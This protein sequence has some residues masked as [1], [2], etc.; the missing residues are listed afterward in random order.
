LSDFIRPKRKVAVLVG[1]QVADLITTSRAFLAIW[2]PWLGITSGESSLA[3]VV[4]ALILNWTGDALDGT[5]ARRSS[6]QYHTWIGDH[7]LEVDVL[8]SIGL[9]FSMLNAGYEDLFVLD[10][11]FL[12]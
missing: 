7:D 12:T 2:L 1:K 5:L 3:T 4:R 10:T 8:V 9:L 6:K 11:F